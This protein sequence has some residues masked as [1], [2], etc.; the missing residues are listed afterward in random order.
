MV[1]CR[2]RARRSNARCPARIHFAHLPSGPSGDHSLIS[3]PAQNALSDA[4]ATSTT[5]LVG[6]EALA[7]RFQL[8]QHRGG[9]GVQL[10]RPVEHDAADTSFDA[11]AHAHGF[12]S[13][14][15]SLVPAT[16]SPFWFFTLKASTRMPRSA[17]RLA[18][19]LHLDLGVDAIAD[20][21]RAREL[22]VRR[23]K[24]RRGRLGAILEPSTIARPRSRA[25]RAR[26][27]EPHANWSSTCRSKIPGQPGEAHDVALGNDDRAGG[28]AFSAL[29]RTS[30]CHLALMR[31]ASRDAAPC[32]SRKRRGSIVFRSFAT[33]SGMPACDSIAL[34][35]D[36]GCDL[37]DHE[38]LLRASGRSAR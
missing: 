7:S 12:L 18:L 35:I 23:A 8:L 29:G 21:D 31:R 1:G 11:R 26:E 20:Q 2:R 13:T 16:T 33:T 25:R 3:A 17:L 36:A 24:P 9:E 6:L 38:P 37:G 27:A 10:F 22:P 15:R 5:R 4:E 28:K 14:I 34:E 19:G 30:S 32:G